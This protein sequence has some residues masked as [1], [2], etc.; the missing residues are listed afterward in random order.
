MFVNTLNADDKYSLHNRENLRQP[1]QMQFSKKQKVF[2]KEFA[3]FLKSASSF[4]HCEKK[5]SLIAYLFPKLETAK[6][7][8][9]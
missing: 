4:E 3:T 7:V 5:I 8:V 6:N 2:S 9:S 1:I